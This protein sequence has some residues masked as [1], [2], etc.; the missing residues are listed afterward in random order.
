MA[1]YLVVQAEAH[2]GGGTGPIKYTWVVEQLMKLLPPTIK[3]FIT[4][5]DI[6]DI[7]YLLE[8]D[9]DNAKDIYRIQFIKQRYK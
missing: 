8:G 4:E 3:R 2:F 9:E 5:K 6:E 7:K 1:Y